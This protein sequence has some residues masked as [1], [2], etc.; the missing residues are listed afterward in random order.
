[1]SKKNKRK[2]QTETATTAI[3][4]GKPFYFVSYST[5]E[6]QLSVLLECCEIVFG[7]YFEGRRTPFALESGHSQHDV[8]L[9]HVGKCAFGVVCLDGLRPNVVFEYGA[10]RGAKKSVLLFKETSA[11]V[12]IGHFFANAAALSLQPP[13]IDMDKYFSDTKDRFYV[14]WN[15]FHVKQTV[16][17]IWEAYNKIRG[18]IRGVEI[19][20]PKL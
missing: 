10:M 17:T 1:M 15:R 5:G 9:D 19:P 3:V 16:K 12:D 6:P 11:T 18:E 14:E 7:P 8:I 4:S 2:K 13:L 20:E